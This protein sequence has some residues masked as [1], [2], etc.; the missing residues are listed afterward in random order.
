MFGFFKLKSIVVLSIIPQSIL[1]TY[2]IVFIFFFIE[3]AFTHNNRNNTKL[4]WLWSRS[5]NL[6]IHPALQSDKSVIVNSH[7][8]FGQFQSFENNVR[9]CF[10]LLTGK[11]S[12]W[13]TKFLKILSGKNVEIYDFW[14]SANLKRK[15][16]EIFC[17][18]SRL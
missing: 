4:V 2:R 10:K 5:I 11:V 8:M 1:D 18:W 12:G 6:G 3:N 16:R 14:K 13:W 7:W 15:T 17:F 9:I